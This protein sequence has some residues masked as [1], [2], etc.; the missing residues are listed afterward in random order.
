MTLPPVVVGSPWQTGALL[1]DENPKI[2]FQIS[3]DI[4][5]V[6]QYT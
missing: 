1:I 3:D 5:N 2:V 4:R 6:D